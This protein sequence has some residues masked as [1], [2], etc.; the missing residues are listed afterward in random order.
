MPDEAPKATSIS[1]LMESVTRIHEHF[2]A[3]HTWYRGHSSEDYRLLPSAYRSMDRRSD[4][5]P[6]ALEF[7]ARATSRHSA[8]PH[9]DDHVAWLMFMRHYGMP[10]RLLDWT[11]SLLVATYFAVHDSP[12]GKKSQNGQI[13]VLHPGRLNKS[14]GYGE[15]LFSIR[16][17]PVVALAEAVFEPLQAQSEHARKI[18]AF[19][20][21]EIDARMV[22]QQA[23]YTIHGAR[24][25]LSKH[26][27]APNVGQG[28]PASAKKP[29]ASAVAG[30]MLRFITIPHDAKPKL[31]NA[32][33]VLGIRKVNLFPDLAHLSEW[34]PEFV[35]TKRNQ[36]LGYLDL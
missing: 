16:S 3:T 5:R 9:N 17:E 36:D 10:T 19:V 26:L 27:E 23:V 8:C 30:E 22:V 12:G 18:V 2:Q 24:N 35:L 13:C 33:E 29:V 21:Q 25:E 11:E 6:C 28:A 14:Q 34:I 15:G 1:E 7:R 4:E 20:G 32:L 31:R